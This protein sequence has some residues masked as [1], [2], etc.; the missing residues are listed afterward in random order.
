MKEFISLAKISVLL[1]ICICFLF[2][3]DNAFTDTE[4]RIA[5]P[6]VKKYTGD[7][8]K[9][10][11]SLDNSLELTSYRT[12]TG[13][14][15]M[16]PFSL[17][18]LEKGKTAMKEDSRKNAIKFFKDAITL[19]PDMPQSYIYMAKAN[20][21]FSSEGITSSVGY[22]F[23]AW[24]ALTNNIWWSFRVAGIFMSSLYLSLYMS[25]VA[26]FIILICSGF[27]LYLHDV[28]EDA[29]K[30]FLLLP[31]IVLLFIGPVFSV[32]A[33]ILPFWSYLKEKEKGLLYGI[34][35][36]VF[37]VLIEGLLQGEGE[38]SF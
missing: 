9:K 34:F 25:V 21:S 12:I 5:E 30:I 17:A 29:R 1:I 7:I 15:N 14:S 4:N 28:M 11:P 38:K 3:P 16:V 20:F 23:S 19:S 2:F 24:K 33:F 32:V 22:L 36:A 35:I 8:S 10:Y 37:A 13:F 31:A 26:L 18:L 27:R 6:D